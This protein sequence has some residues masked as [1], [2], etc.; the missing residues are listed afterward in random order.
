MPRWIVDC[1]ECGREFTHTLISRLGFARDPFA[2]PPK[3]ELSASGTDL[4]CPNCGE[5]STY[6]GVDLRYSA[7]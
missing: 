3:A 6:K 5:T 7:D 4:K 1:P 2:S